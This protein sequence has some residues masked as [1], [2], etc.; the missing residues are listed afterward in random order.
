MVYIGKFLMKTCSYCLEELPRED[1]YID[2]RYVMSS[3]CKSCHGISIRTCT[4]CGTK[5]Q[6]RFNISYC[7]DACRKQARPQT[8]KVCLQ[9]KKRFGPVNHLTRKYCSVACSRAAR[10]TGIKII[11]KGIPEA[12]KAWSL[13]A[14]HL[15]AGKLKKPDACEVCGTKD[16]RL[17]AS[18]S[19]YSRPLDVRWLCKSCHA[20]EDCANPKNATVRIFLKSDDKRK[21]SSGRRVECL[22]VKSSLSVSTAGKAGSATNQSD[23]IEEEDALWYSTS[24]TAPANAEAVEEVGV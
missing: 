6:G 7:S 19:D 24:D 18:H 22:P 2:R 23:L 10:R 5:F 12:R 8:F 1:F 9:C 17:E 15:K 14:Y 4:V 16:K 11:H 20:K 3:R 21:E 13:V